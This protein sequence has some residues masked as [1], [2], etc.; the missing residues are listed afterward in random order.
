MRTVFS[1][2]VCQWLLE[3]DVCQPLAA[4]ACAHWQPLATEV[5][6]NTAGIQYSSVDAMDSLISLPR[7]LRRFYE[8]NAGIIAAC[9]QSEDENLCTILDFTKQN[10]TLPLQRFSYS[11]ISIVTQIMV[12]SLPLHPTN[13]S[14][15]IMLL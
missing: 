15:V 2:R 13:P 9:S 5:K 8:M 6:P 14:H 4:T 1:I 11:T 12:L 7:R 3:Y 10:A